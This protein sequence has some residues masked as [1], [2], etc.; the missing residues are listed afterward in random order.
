META[1]K[2]KKAITLRLPIYLID[3]LKELATKEGIILN[4]Y[5]VNLLTEYTDAK[6]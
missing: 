5:V 6:S 4:Q 3:M 2:K 1:L